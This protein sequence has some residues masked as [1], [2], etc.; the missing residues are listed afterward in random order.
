M[1]ETRAPN[2]LLASLEQNSIQLNKGSVQ[3]NVYAKNIGKKKPTKKQ[4]L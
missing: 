3:M 1:K 2:A 4:R